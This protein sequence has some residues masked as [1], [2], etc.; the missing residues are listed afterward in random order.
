MKMQIITSCLALI[1]ALWSLNCST[2]DQKLELPVVRKTPASIDVA[3]KSTLK[4]SFAGHFQNPIFS[5]DSKKLFF[6]SS[7]YRGIYYYDLSTEQQYTL[8]E[9]AGSGYQF[10]ISADGNRVFYRAD[11]PMVKKRRRFMIYEQNVKTGEIRKL[12]KQSVRELSPPRSVNEYTIVFT[13]GDSLKLLNVDQ[14]QEKSVQ[15]IKQSYYRIHKNQLS[16]YDSGQRTFE[17]TFPNQQ[18]LWPDFNK[19]DNRMIVYISGEGLQLIDLAE[20][21]SRFL[22]NF[23][24][25]KWSPFR[26]LIV[27][28]Q[29][30]DDGQ[31]TLASDIFIHNLQNN[32][33]FNLTNTDDIIEM[34]PDWSPDGNKI[35]Y[36]TEKGKIEI[37]ELNLK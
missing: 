10:V 24:A 3:R 37:L 16:I 14:V 25:A 33:S 2:S 1:L 26:D 23:R 28:M 27:Y 35:A 21:K 8:N 32:K 15:E 30:K 22:G 5:A 6:T 31:R 18:I 13:Q 17:K 20:N 7:T 12:L 9:E 4:T 36:H 34:Y 19:T 29:D 11:A